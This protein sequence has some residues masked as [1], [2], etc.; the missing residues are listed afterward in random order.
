MRAALI[1]SNNVFHARYT[2]ESWLE[3]MIIFPC[4]SLEYFLSGGN[5]CAI[6]FFSVVNCYSV[7]GTANAMAYK[8]LQQ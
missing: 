1:I 6:V 5:N 3:S 8:M 7:V 2:E 4:F